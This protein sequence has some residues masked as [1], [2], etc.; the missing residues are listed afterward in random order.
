[1]YKVSEPSTT[2]HFGT[3]LSVCVYDLNSLVRP[4]NFSLDFSFNDFFEIGGNCDWK[5]SRSW[6]RSEGEE[7]ER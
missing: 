7:V 1:M 4:L 3:D 6:R 5:S 2:N